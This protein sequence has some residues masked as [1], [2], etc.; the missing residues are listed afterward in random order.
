MAWC[1]PNANGLR[2]QQQKQRGTAF[3]I[4]SNTQ[5]QKRT[6]CTVNWLQSK[7]GLNK[8]YEKEYKELKLN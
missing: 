1:N 5:M 2:N 6:L 7:K 8:N 3:V 4:Q